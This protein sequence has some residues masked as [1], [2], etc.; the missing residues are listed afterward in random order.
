MAYNAEQLESIHSPLFANPKKP[1]GM[2]SR[3]AG[4]KFMKRSLHRRERMRRRVDVNN[5]PEYKKYDGWE[6]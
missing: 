2:R 1:W 4:R 5:E 3:S 6:Y